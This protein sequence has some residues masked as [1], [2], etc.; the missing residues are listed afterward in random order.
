MNEPLNYKSSGVDIDAANSLKRELKALLKNDDP[1]VL[2]GVGAFGSLYRIGFPEMSDP[3][4]VLKTEEPGSK[5][6]LAFQHDRFESIGRDMINHLIND[7]IVMGARPLAV[8]DAIICGRLE[9]KRVKRMIAGIDA[10]CRAQGC[11]LTG[12]E[13]SE[14]PAVIEAGRYILTASVVGI[15][16]RPDVVDGSAIRAG[17]AVLALES[18]GLH[19]NGYSLVRTLLERNPDLERR[20][21]GGA[22][23]IDLVLEPHRC[24][25]THLKDLFAKKIIRGMAHVT[26]G[27]IR[28]NLDR[29]LP[30]DVDAAVDLS[31]YRVPAVFS[32]I[33]EESGVD[34]DEMLRT[35]NLGVGLAV[36]C[37]PYDAAAIIAH[38]KENSLP[39]WRIGEIVKGEGRVTT[40]GALQWA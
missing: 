16:D 22:S 26:G 18:S 21:V 37:A 36:V 19:T 20:P 33:R 23:F 39:A 10:A 5:Q 2:N 32:V 12:G 17:D 14:Q 8:Q 28:E 11:T 40:R 30:K 29:I 35:F 38:L 7:C 3:V 4:L 6:L 15:V 1:R 13:I 25:Y 34:D 9:K 31:A 24:Y 27:G